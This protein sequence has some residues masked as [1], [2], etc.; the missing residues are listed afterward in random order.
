MQNLSGLSLHTNIPLEQPLEPTQTQESILKKKNTLLDLRN[1]Q[2]EN[3]NNRLKN[4]LSSYETL[5]QLYTQTQAEIEYLKSQVEILQTNPQHDP[6][7]LQEL[8]TRCEAAEI[9]LESQ[10]N[11][12]S[13]I[14]LQLAEQEFTIG[15]LTKKMKI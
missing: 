1:L 10:G 15:E 5:Q 7:S 11:E 12:L 4:I 3:E 8:T 2:L 13:A 9:K 14:K 6:R